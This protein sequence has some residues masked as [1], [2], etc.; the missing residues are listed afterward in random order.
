MDGRAL[1]GP[2]DMARPARHAL[3]PLPPD[4]RL[5]GSPQRPDRGPARPRLG[6]RPGTGRTGNH[7][8]HCL[9]PA[10]LCPHWAGLL[11]ARAGRGS[12]GTWA[13][14]PSPPRHAAQLARGPAPA[15]PRPPRRGREAGE[16]AERRAAP[17]ARR[18]CARSLGPLGSWRSPS[19][20]RG[21]PAGATCCRRTNVNG[22]QRG[23]RVLEDPVPLY[24][25]SLVRPRAP[26][27]VSRD[28]LA[29][30]PERKEL[31]RT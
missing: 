30:N 10:G 28:L 18:K 3:P 15:A 13:A 24:P 7:R 21:R 8:R 23:K 31:R 29:S 4:V 17:P 9:R 5:C 27:H 26:T 16:G 11:R 19:P 1:G 12:A 2:P 20:P 22:H 6:R 25:P 14:A